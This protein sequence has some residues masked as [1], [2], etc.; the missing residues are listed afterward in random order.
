MANEGLGWDPLLKMVHNPGGDWNPGRGGQP[1]FLYCF[2]IRLSVL[3]YPM[4]H[5]E[6]MV[7][8]AFPDM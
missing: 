7:Y 2:F 1:K 6:V 4:T 3:Y 8:F 5:F